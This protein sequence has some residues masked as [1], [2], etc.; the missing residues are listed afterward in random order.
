MINYGGGP[1]PWLETPFFEVIDAHI[2]LRE[3]LN[4][5]QSAE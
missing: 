4:T 5:Q 2:D 1:L 3:R